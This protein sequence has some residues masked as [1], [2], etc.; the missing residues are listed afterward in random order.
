MSANEP[1][2]GTDPWQPPGEGGVPPPPGQYPPPPPPPPPPA[3]GYPAAYPPPAGGYPPAYPVPPGGYPPGYP[4]PPR[5][6]GKSIAILVLGIAGLFLTCA[7][8]L[9]VVAAIVA[10]ALAPGAN[11]EI[12]ASQGTLTGDGMI[13]AG[14]ICAWITVGLTVL[15]ILFIV[16][17]IIGAAS[18]SAA[19]GQAADV[20]SQNGAGLVALVG[21]LPQWRRWSGTPGAARGEEN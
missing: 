9:G 5:N 16:V 17:I 21:L 18:S 20:V 8:G 1:P 11:R 15:G 14:V 4:M 6:S 7:Y 10:L 2:G 13:K 19:T 12:A 3:G